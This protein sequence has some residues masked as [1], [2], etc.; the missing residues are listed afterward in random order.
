MTDNKSL[1]DRATALRYMG[2]FG[3][4]PQSLTEALCKVESELCRVMTPRYVYRIVDAD[5]AEK[6][7]RGDDVKRLVRGCEKI[8]VLAST[9]G[10]PTDDL[11]RRYQSTDVLCAMIAD[12]EASAAVDVLCDEVMREISLQTKGRL[13]A[14]FSPGYGD[15]PLEA[16]SELLDFA[17]AGRKIGL[18]VT[19]SDM[20]TPIKSVSAVAGL[21][22]KG[23]DYET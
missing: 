23:F 5:E 12:A 8:V 22:L 13:T 19:D 21:M 14:R 17:D 16:Q 1:I 18:F 10:S 7:L 3:D 2:C 9:L 11:I 6:I 4:A 20:M 15:F